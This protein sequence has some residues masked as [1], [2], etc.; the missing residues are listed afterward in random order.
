MA[1]SMK[2]QW[3]DLRVELSRTKPG[4]AQERAVYSKLMQL[5]DKVHPKALDDWL[6]NG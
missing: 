6:L 3:D 5:E 2:E 1:K 4:S